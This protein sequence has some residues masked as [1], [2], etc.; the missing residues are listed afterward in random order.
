MASSGD[1][2]PSSAFA[3]V[4]SPSV[5]RSVEGA[6][7]LAKSLANTLVPDVGLSPEVN[8]VKFWLLL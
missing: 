1:P 8:M 4:L 7:A 3:A 5:N 6:V 2:L